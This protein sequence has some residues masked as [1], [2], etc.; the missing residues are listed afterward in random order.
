MAQV[1]SGS[2][3]CGPSNYLGLL[4]LMAAQP[5]AFTL[6]PGAQPVHRPVKPTFDVPP[7]VGIGASLEQIELTLL[8]RVKMSANLIQSVIV[9]VVKA[10]GVSGL[11]E[12][13]SGLHLLLLLVQQH[14]QRVPH[15]Y[16]LARSECE[17]PEGC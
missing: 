15:R 8:V 4:L 12:A 6:E 10:A 14:L 13:S 16:S 2:G 17:Q 9:G 7:D 11:S 3:W 1:G 5:V